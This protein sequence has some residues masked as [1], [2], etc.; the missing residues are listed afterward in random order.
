MQF[1]SL[2]LSFELLFSDHCNFSFY[3]VQREKLMECVYV[4]VYVQELFVNPK[5]Q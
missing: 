2:E 1:V 3:S 4:C 5:N